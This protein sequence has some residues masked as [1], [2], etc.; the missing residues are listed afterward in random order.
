MDGLHMYAV[1]KSRLSTRGRKV[2]RQRSPAMPAGQG[3]S[4][5]DEE[6][7]G[8]HSRSQSPG[9]MLAGI[10]SGIERS[11]HELVPG[12]SAL[13]KSGVVGHL[14]HRG[15]V[16]GS[17]SH[18]APSAAQGAALEDTM[19]TRVA[20]VHH[21]ATEQELGGSLLTRVHD[22]SNA[23]SSQKQN[24]AAFSRAR[25]EGH[26][27]VVVLHYTRNGH[28]RFHASGGAD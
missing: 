26:G 4:M 25:L 22:T 3:A 27:G 17:G 21:A 19:R 14:P 23:S 11:Q 7:H 10:M 6:T 5:D 1:V 13:I 24:A 9:S 2:V 18:R 20:L 16:G 8:S 28:L 15:Y 12:A